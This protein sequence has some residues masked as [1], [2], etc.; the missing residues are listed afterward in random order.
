[1][2]MIATCTGSGQVP[3][4]EYVRGPDLADTLYYLYTMDFGT[5]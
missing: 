2:L 3:A 4:L 1:M 5:R